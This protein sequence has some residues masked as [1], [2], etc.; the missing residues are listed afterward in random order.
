MT[1]LIKFWL[2]LGLRFLAAML[3]Y[4]TRYHS[5]I[6][7]LGI[8]LPA[9]C[10]TFKIS[11]WKKSPEVSKNDLCTKCVPNVFRVPKPHKICRITEPLTHETWCPGCR[12]AENQKHSITLTL[13]QPTTPLTRDRLD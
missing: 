11:H 10:K 8:L 1:I 6:L 3:V 9:L 13:L 2:Y 7:A 4:Q 5:Q 12:T